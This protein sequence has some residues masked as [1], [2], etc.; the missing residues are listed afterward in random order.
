MSPA[1]KKLIDGPTNNLLLRISH[2]QVNDWLIN[3]KCMSDFVDPSKDFVTT[4]VGFGTT[5]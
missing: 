3:L 4:H 1:L 2:R 5:I